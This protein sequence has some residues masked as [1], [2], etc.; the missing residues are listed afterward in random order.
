MADRPSHIASSLLPEQ[1]DP[2]PRV[3]GGAFLME[4]LITVNALVSVL[5]LAWSALVLRK[6]DRARQAWQY[7]R[8]AWPGLVGR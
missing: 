1:E 2:A 8:R 3:R 4:R 6:P 5:M 7:L